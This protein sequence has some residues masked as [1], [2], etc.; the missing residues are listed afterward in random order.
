[1]S[2]TPPAWNSAWV[3]VVIALTEYAPGTDTSPAIK[4]LMAR[5]RPMETT[6]S[7]PINCCATRVLIKSRASSKVRPDKV[8]DPSFGKLTSPDRPTCRLSCSFSFPNNCT[9]SWSPT[10]NRYDSGTGASSVGAKVDTSR[11]NNARPYRVRALV[12]TSSVL[13]GAAAWTSACVMPVADGSAAPGLA[14]PVTSPEPALPV[15]KAMPYCLAS[16][17]CCAGDMDLSWLSI[18]GETPGGSA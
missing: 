8:M 3:T 16:A 17:C 11:L 5:N 18:A 12:C 1:M 13:S 2:V 4:T 7:T 6:T 15:G 10:P 9:I 14:K